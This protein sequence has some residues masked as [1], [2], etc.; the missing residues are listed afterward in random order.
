MVTATETTQLD[1]GERAA[2]DELLGGLLPD[3]DMAASELPDSMAGVV[4]PAAGATGWTGWP[5]SWSR[6]CSTPSVTGRWC[7]RRPAC[8][9]AVPWTLLPGFVGRPVTVA[10]SATSWLARHGDARCGRALPGFVAGPRVDRAED[11][12][13]RGR[14]GVAPGPRC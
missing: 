3:L 10:Q 9:P 13:R 1:L 2:L 11:E 7:S 5:R 12:V 8:W 4:R 6:R 14:Q